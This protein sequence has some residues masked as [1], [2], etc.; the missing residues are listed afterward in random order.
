[1]GDGEASEE[2]EPI[3]LL[4]TVSGAPLSRGLATQPG[5][6]GGSEPHA[7]GLRADS[8]AAAPRRL[9]GA[10]LGCLGF[11]RA[12]VPVRA[13]TLMCS[14]HSF[15]QNFTAPHTA[16]APPPQFTTAPATPAPLALARSLQLSISLSLALGLQRPAL[17][18]AGETR[19]PH[20]QTVG[21]GRDSFN[22]KKPLSG[23]EDLERDASA[24]P[25]RRAP[26]RPAPAVRST[27]KRGQRAT[28]ARLQRTT[29][30]ASVCA[31]CW[32]SSPTWRW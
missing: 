7:S 27:G 30:A 10:P 8:P 17:P 1:M 11:V 25:T 18:R 14:S 9:D 31:P 21:L 28:A 32:T 22:E 12:G 26:G 16:A 2:R 4:I 29:G 20:T 13:V 15:R 6:P 19:C 5:P 3:A 24:F 23:G